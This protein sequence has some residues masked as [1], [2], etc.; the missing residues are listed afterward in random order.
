MNPL[1][2]EGTNIQCNETEITTVIFDNACSQK[3]PLFVSKEKGSHNCIAPSP[4]HGRSLVVNFDSN[5]NR[6]IITKGN[7]LTYFPYGFVSTEELDSYAWGLL[8]KE[9]AIRDFQGSNFVSSLGITTNKMEALFTL[10]KQPIRFLDK[11]E[12]IEPNILQYSVQSPYRIADIPFL[13]PQTIKK[14]ID[15]WYLLSEHKHQTLHCLAA[16]ILLKNI[17][18]MHDNNVLHNAIHSQNYTLA[19][20][21][22]DFELTRTP[23]TPYQN[24]KDEATFSTLQKR[25]VIQSLEIV[26][27]IAFYFKEIIDSKT[28]NDLMCQYGYDNYV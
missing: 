4:L 3:Y 22:L 1:Q 26:N 9:D 28:L 25:E 23:K 11:L 12:F 24:K 16:E 6:Y 18:I 20:E 13:K 2:I 21:L 5:T 7:G 10:E 27:H 19:L 14:H 8:R 15:E 17:K